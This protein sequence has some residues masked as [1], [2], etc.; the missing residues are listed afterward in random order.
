MRE[1]LRLRGH[2]RRCK[3]FDHYLAQ[4]VLTLLE[5]M[6]AKTREILALVK[7][8]EVKLRQSRNPP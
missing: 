8:L 1:T 5:Q 4:E 7:R 6:E 3:M 2:E